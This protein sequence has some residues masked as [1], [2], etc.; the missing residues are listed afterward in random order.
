M[1]TLQILHASD[2]EGS[3]DAIDDAPN[4]AAIVDALEEDAA[5]LGISSILLSS[6]DNYIP[7]PLFNAGGDFSLDVTYEGFYNALFGLIDESALDAAAD[8]NGDGFFDNGEIEAAILAGDTTFDAVYTTDVNGDG[9]KDYFEEI[10]TFEGRIDIAIMN[11]LGV[12]A[13]AVGNHEFDAGTDSFE[14]TINYDSE[15]GNSLST[16]RYDSNGLVAGHVNYLQEVD[17]PGVQFPYLTA[18]L[19]FSQ[20]FDLGPLFTSDILP[21]TDFI[22]DLLSARANPADP[23]ETSGDSNDSKVAPATIIERDGEMIGVVGATTQIV[24]SISST[25]TIA[26]FSNGGTGNDMAALAAVLQPVVDALTADGV[27]KIVLVSHLQQFALEQELASLLSGVDVILAGG[28]DTISADD[29]DR[30]RTEDAGAETQPYPVVVQDLDGN[31]TAIVSTDGEYSYVGRLVID[32]DEDGHII[33]S[34]I[35]ENVSGAY[36]T[37]EQGVLDVTGEA[38]IE[39]AIANS[40]KATDVANLASSVVDIVTAT[41]AD[42]AGE[43]DVFL[44]GLREDIRTQET[45]LGNLTADANIAAV[46]AAGFAATVSIKN[47]GG[48]RAPIGEI[49]DNGDGTASFNTTAA[50]PLSGKEEGEVSELDIDNALRFNNSLVV[51]E[52]SAED[53]KI[54]LEHAVAGVADGATPGQFPQVGGIWFSFDPDGDAQVLD[55]NGVPTT[56]GSRVQSVA[57]LDENGNPSQIIVEDGEVVEGAPESIQVVTLNFLAGG[58]DGYPFGLLGPVTETGIGEQEALSDYLTENFPEGG[59]EAFDIEDTPMSEDLRIQN[60]DARYDSVDT[61]IGTQDLRFKAVATFQGDSGDPD[62][63]EGASEVVSHEDGVLYVTNG[64]NDRI[65]IFDIASE[66]QTGFIELDGLDGYDGVQS[67]SVKNGV[68]AVA[69]AGEPVD[70]TVFGDEVTLSQPGFVA[71]FDASTGVLLST[72]EVGN[73]PDMLTFNADGTSL[74][75]AGEGEKNADS[76]HDDNPLGTVAVIDTTDPANPVAEVLNFTQFNGLEERAIDA[77]IRIQVG[78][79]FGSD[80]EPEYI[81]I[82]PDGTTAFV[83]L[84]ENNAIAKID[85]ATNEIVNIFSQG[86]TD[87]SS[88][89]ELDADDNG[90]INITNFDNLV[91]FR[92]ADAIASFEVNGQTF[93]ATANEGDSRDFDEDRVEDLAEDGLLDE[94]IDITGLERLE[95]STLDGDTDGDGDIDVLHTFSSRSFSIYDEN[96]N[97]VFDSG[98][99]FEKIIAQV[100]PERFN[101]D[102][103]EDGES[104]SDAKG[105][106]PEAITVGAV[107]DKTYAF[108][109]LERDSGIMIYDVTDPSNSTFVDYIPGFDDEAGVTDGDHLGPEVITFI[110]AED[111]TTGNAQIAVA[112]EISG[113][114][115]VY[116]IQPNTPVINEVV[117]SHTGTDDTEFVELFGK[118]G[119]SLEGL[120]LVSINA[121]ASEAG[122]LNLRIDFT[123]DD[124]IGDNGFFL[125]GNAAGLQANYGVLP[126]V[127]IDTNQFENDSQIFALVETASLVVDGS[128]V[129]NDADTVVVDS[130]GFINSDLDYVSFFDAPAVGPDGIFL[131]AGGFRLEDGV[132]TDSADD[133]GLANF[134]LT[135]NTPTAG[136]GLDSAIEIVTIP[137]IQGA[138]HVSAFVGSTVLT[139]GIVTAIDFAGYY[140]QDPEGDGDIATSDAIFVFTGNGNVPAELAIG[141]EV[142]IIGSVDEFIPGGADTGNLSVTQLNPSSTTIL[143]SGNE[144]PEATLLGAA[145]RLPP[146]EV[147][148]SEDEFPVNLQDEPGTFNPDVDGIDFYESLEGMLVTVDNPVA[149]SATN[150]FDETWVVTDDGARVTSGSEDGG[151]NDRGALKINAD[152]DG[153]GDLNPERIQIQYDSFFD[154]VDEAETPGDIN[155]GDNLS[156]ITG[157]VSYEFGNYQVMVTEGFEVE[158]PSSNVAEVT[159]IEGGSNE[160]TVATYNVLNVT[161]NPDDG[162]AD[163]IEA[164]AAQIVANL[165]SPDILAL[166]EI[167]DNSGVT[168]DG[169]LSADE[170]LQ[171]LVDAIVEAGG[172]LYSFES[173]IVDEDG[174]N[175]GVPGGNIRNAFLYNEERVS[176]SEVV[177]LESNELADLGVT[178]SDAFDGTRDPLLGV[179]EFNGQE[180]TLINNHFSSRF[181]SEPIF[182]GPQP[183]NQGGEDEREAQALALNEVVDALL[184]EDSGARVVVLGDLNTFEFTDELTEDLPGVGDEKVLTNLMD[185]LAEDDAYTF[186]FDGNAQI[187]DNLFV[188]DELFNGGFEIDIVHVNNDFADFASDHEPVVASFTFSEEGL[189]LEG[190]NAA[191]EL[192]GGEDDDEIFGFNNV[193]ILIGNGGDDEI[194]GGSGFDEI[195]GG[196]GEDF[197]DGGTQ[198]DSL[199]GGADDDIILAGRGNDVIEGG[200]GNDLMTGDGGRDSFIFDGLFGD[201]QITDF[202]NRQDDLQFLGVDAG[203]IS[204]AVVGTDTVITVAGAT[205][206]GTVTLLGV[207]DFEFDNLVV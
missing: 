50:N 41:D 184:A 98:S 181:G 175:G 115:V 197:I 180:I 48:I 187:L 30:L 9:F 204:T 23:T 76:D 103:G 160:L 186:I 56:V 75:V 4:F 61:P 11:A 126:N 53:L 32:F 207:D 167:Q 161:S 177:T 22:S 21:N 1:F 172:P 176:L 69:I 33:A 119:D 203:D 147:V 29:Q 125:I 148:I 150:R 155:V 54:V 27:N 112:Y 2:L 63:A 99:D 66:T 16:S 55:A 173:A 141:D 89:S 156:D 109:G 102:D 196:D 19:D 81:S 39:D 134:N 179:F 77:G 114:T 67:V 140:I 166:Q 101:D 153:L 129:V 142:E 171:A 88:E 174:E 59:D 82:S 170:T 100:A 26:D 72:V 178:N 206:Q 135:E 17:T 35:D 159:D 46:N 118:A 74:L 12:D 18:N 205:T 113:T 130:V 90:E 202:S 96:G 40:E 193:D 146:T 149:I 85:L 192:E 124:V 42:I 25:G 80:V 169:T 145:G 8:T 79:S 31:D 116:D 104:R 3:V 15:E 117:F 47:G 64:A 152:I 133:F 94:S 91:G 28:S 70:A 43:S 93:I 38:T 78:V 36:A 110:P 162:D 198:S 106:E 163:Q 136:T 188:T 158:T 185:F 131:P 144:L 121:N 92:M 49:V 87:F 13:S 127:T 86:V 195:F 58:G 20:D 199:Y 84:Q 189:V 7:G 157:V 123:A 68:V 107:G 65:D 5:S 71:L 6:G 44:N 120:S 194:F 182:G 190:T 143:S 154:L 34:S 108:I 62:D 201:D 168:D 57:L 139:S 52:L 37:D 132:D 164:L 60:L 165:G 45:N 24:S 10:D 151:L 122:D 51:V 73:L 105:P 111:S 95:V 97:L 200:E 137:E 138:G 191:D 14:N 83:S 128:T 183:F